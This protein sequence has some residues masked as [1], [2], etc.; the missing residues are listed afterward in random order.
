MIINF[1]KYPCRTP[2]KVPSGIPTVI[3]KF[4][5]LFYC[6][7]QKNWIHYEQLLKLI[8][9][10]LKYATEIKLKDYTNLKVLLKNAIYLCEHHELSN[11]TSTPS[12]STSYEYLYDNE[13]EAFQ[14]II[15]KIRRLLLK[16]LSD[17]ENNHNFSNSEKSMMKQVLVE[18]IQYC[19]SCLNTSSQRKPLK[20]K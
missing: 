15:I 8:L 2:E 11:I 4:N 7:S 17:F 3:E 10:L 19:N 5:N 16:I 20:K 18:A 1:L 6:T 13:L 14:C 9:Q 12:D